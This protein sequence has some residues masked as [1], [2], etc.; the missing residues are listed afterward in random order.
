MINAATETEQRRKLHASAACMLLP[1]MSDDDDDVARMRALTEDLLRTESPCGA[2][3]GERSLN[4]S[5][6][7][8]RHYC[9][10]RTGV[11]ISAQRYSVG[12]G[13]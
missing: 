4:T 5:R 6:T 11:A 9:D 7:G 12:L 10:P 8:W 3:D 2:R 13:R 1:S